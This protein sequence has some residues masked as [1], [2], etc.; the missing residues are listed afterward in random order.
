M[1][2]DYRKFVESLEEICNEED[3]SLHT[4]ETLS[5]QDLLKDIVGSLHD[6]V[7]KISSEDVEYE[8]LI[9]KLQKAR[10]IL[11]DVG[12]NEPSLDE[13]AGGDYGTKGMG[14]KIGK[15]GVQNYDNP[16]GSSYAARHGFV[17]I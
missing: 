10:D 16:N 8:D 1:D 7:G 3:E 11:Q 15:D 2:Y 6:I 9:K 14:P 12:Y 5:P 17:G 4:E 13:E